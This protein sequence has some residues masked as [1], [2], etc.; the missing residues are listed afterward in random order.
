[1]RH[2]LTLC[3]EEKK[4]FQQRKKNVLEAMK[5]ILGEAAPQD[6]K[7]VMSMQY[8]LPKIEFLSLFISL[9]NEYG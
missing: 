8:P 1:M 3:D 6:V 9:F 4:F 5:D 2:S 7:H